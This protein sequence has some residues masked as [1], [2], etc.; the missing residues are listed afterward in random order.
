MFWSKKRKELGA[1][2]VVRSNL[3]GAR[4]EK[5]CLWLDTWVIQGEWRKCSCPRLVPVSAAPLDSGSIATSH[6]LMSLAS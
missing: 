5:G 2:H 4:R 6:E 1:A 3:S